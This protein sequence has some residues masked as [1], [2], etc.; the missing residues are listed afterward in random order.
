[1]FLIRWMFS[2]STYTPRHFPS[3]LLLLLPLPLPQT[4]FFLVFQTKRNNPWTTK[5]WTREGIK[6]LR[7]YATVQCLAPRYH[8]TNLMKKLVHSIWCLY[9]E[10][11]GQFPY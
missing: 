10:C 6:T 9:K 7:W 1:M 11:S 2:S 8:S 3:S 5:N 4:H